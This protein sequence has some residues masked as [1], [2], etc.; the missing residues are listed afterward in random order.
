[1]KLLEDM[2]TDD[3]LSSIAKVMDSN[4]SRFDRLVELAKLD[5]SCDFRDSD[6]RGLDFCGADLRGF[7]FTRSDLRGCLRSPDTVIDDTT[8][9]LDARVDWIEVSDPS[10]VE[11]MRKI[12]GATSSDQRNEL[13]QELIHRNDLTDHV[14]QFLV[15][16]AEKSELLDE[17]L[18]YISFI[19][20]SI[21]H[22]YKEKLSRNGV[23]L[24]DRKLSQTRNRSGKGRNSVVS[25]ELI[26]QRLAHA[27]QSIAGIVF[28]E[29]SSRLFASSRTK[30]LGGIFGVEATDL[31]SAFLDLGR[32]K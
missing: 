24:V 9:F 31:R 23:K 21:D 16:S 10:V 30:K 6:L 11:Q 20:P 26:V 17:F 3:E 22:H 8:I 15:F 25:V 19:P 5:R 32:K 2:L 7:D 14:V 28:E 29:L 4:I 13:I 27:K 18:D 1:M 12:G